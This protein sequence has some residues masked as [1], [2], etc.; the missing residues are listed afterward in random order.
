[1]ARRRKLTPEQE[2]EILQA[3]AE[4]LG[5]QRL[6]RRFGLGFSLV[7]RVLRR[8]VRP[9]RALL[10]DRS[11]QLALPAP[12]AQMAQA[13]APEVLP[14]PGEA[15]AVFGV[16]R[17]CKSKHVAIITAELC[18]ECLTREMNTFHSR[19]LFFGFCWRC[20]F[21]KPI[22]LRTTGGEGVEGLC[23]AH[24]DAELFSA[25]AQARAKPKEPERDSRGLF[26]DPD[27]ARGQG[28]WRA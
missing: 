18:Q 27:G 22:H 7:A 8:A 24:R 26:F 3:H 5:I 10:P 12:Q 4:G 17:W 19:P 25:I 11:P 1:M 21:D 15:G 14:R 28:C 20:G 6:V 16:C 23:G 13:S 9:Q 2:R